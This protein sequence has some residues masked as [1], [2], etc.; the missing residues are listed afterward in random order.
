MQLNLKSAQKAVTQV[1]VGFLVPATIAVTGVVIAE[2]VVMPAI[3]KIEIR[4]L[5][6]QH[7]KPSDD[8][9]TEQQ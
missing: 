9:Y 1:A 6:K 3:D 2:K 7:E 8:E 5:K 4:N